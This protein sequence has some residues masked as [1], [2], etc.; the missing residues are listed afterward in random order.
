MLIV[1]Y[2]F[3]RTT[4]QQEVRYAGSYERDSK[5][6]KEFM[7][8]VSEH[9]ISTEESVGSDGFDTVCYVLDEEAVKTINTPSNVNTFQTKAD[10]LIEALE[11][12]GYVLECTDNEKSFE[13]EA[14]GYGTV[15]SSFLIKDQYQTPDGVQL[16]IHYEYFVKEIT[17]ICL[18]NQDGTEA[19]YSPMASDIAGIIS[20]EL[21]GEITTAEIQEGKKEFEEWEGHSNQ[22][23]RGFEYREIYVRFLWREHFSEAIVYFRPYGISYEEPEYRW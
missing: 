23:V 11:Q 5:E 9:A 15:K 22:Y 18:S 8:Y 19:D 21:S 16:E 2:I 4:L 14:G 1:G 3:I 13:V 17:F 20:P 6:Y 12:K 7:E 10:E